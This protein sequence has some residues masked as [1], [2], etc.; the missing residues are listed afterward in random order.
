LKAFSGMTPIEHNNRGDIPI[1]PDHWLE[2]PDLSGRYNSATNI[3]QVISGLEPLWETLETECVAECCGLTA[4]NFSPLGLAE[5]KKVLTP[6]TIIPALE[7]AIA[8]IERL[9]VT[10]IL[11]SRLNAISDTG[12]FLEF[13]HYLKQQLSRSENSIG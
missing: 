6:S 5:A 9:G 13:L 7:N 4:F 11:C 10:T 8:E 12:V 3:D 1:G 2:Q